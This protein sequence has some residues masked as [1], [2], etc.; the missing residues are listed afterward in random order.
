M[1]R[2]VCVCVCGG[3]NNRV[4]EGTAG[5]SSALVHGL[6]PPLA[7]RPFPRARSRDWSE[8][9]Q[10]RELSGGVAGW[11]GVVGGGGGVTLVSVGLAG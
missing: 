11:L 6:R 9:D 1:S 5:Q 10:L 7:R 3:G 4:W 8:E 2:V